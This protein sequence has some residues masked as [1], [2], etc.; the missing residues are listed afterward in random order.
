MDKESILRCS[1]DKWYTPLRSETIRSYIIPLP[2]DL[3]KFLL[4]GDFVL[5]PEGTPSPYPEIEKKVSE[6]LEYELDG[7]AF[8]KLNFTAPTDAKG[9]APNRIIVVKSFLD[10][11]RLLKA[12]TRVLIDIIKPF[13][14]EIEGLQPILVL[15]R[16]FNYRQ[17]REFRA[18]IKDKTTYCITS[19]YPHLASTVPP[20]K[21]QN[22]FI[23]FIESIS[24]KYNVDKLILDFYVSPK[25]RLHIIDLAPWNDLTSPGLYTWEEIE[26]LQNVD[27]RIS[28]EDSFAPPED[29]AVPEE[30]LGGVSYEEILASMKIL[31]E[32]IDESQIPSFDI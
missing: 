17:E 31:D 15:K 25:E 21:L 24:S 23:P 8:P 7:M 29:D 5:P 2:P 18:F 20:E 14:T 6:I 9:I 30:L 28:D 32:D 11:L 1:F 27:V 13:G 26:N 10:V 3:I 12:S 16:W 19:R 4:E 22:L